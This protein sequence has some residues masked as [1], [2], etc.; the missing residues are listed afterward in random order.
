MALK[1]DNAMWGQKQEAEDRSAGRSDGGANGALLSSRQAGEAIEKLRSGIEQASGALRDLTQAGE[2]W[3]HGLP[4]RARGM[5]RELRSQGERA[6]GT[7][8]QQVEHNP[9]TSLAVA[10][11]VG[12]I[13]ASLIRR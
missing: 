8:S 10:F 2:E 7:V 9:V 5:A 4:D 13:C 1:E 3:A 11:A 12:F 6:I